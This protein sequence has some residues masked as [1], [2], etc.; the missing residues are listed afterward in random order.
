MNKIYNT[1]VRVMH[2]DNKSVS[3]IGLGCVTFGREIDQDTSFEMMNYAA[4]AGITLFDTS[5]SYGEGVSEEIVG[6]WLSRHPLNCHKISVSTKIQPPFDPSNILDSVDQSL[7]RLKMNKIDIVFLHRWDAAV[8]TLATL[9]SLDDLRKS[10]KVGMLGASNFSIDQLETI[11]GLQKKHGFHT[12]K[13]LQN[14]NNLVIR[15]INPDLEKFCL[16]NDIKIITYSPLGAGFLTGK[17]K[18]GVKEGTRFSVIKG[19]QDIYFNETSFKR[20]EQLQNLSF[21]TGYKPFYLALA[22]ALHRPNIASVLVG[23]RT[24]EQLEQAMSALN[25]NNADILNELELIK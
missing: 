20:L 7:R 10:G 3:A 15:D 5:P 4:S 23:G 17:Y 1:K 22:W 25:F 18:G 24:T 9:K 13:F 8:E 16:N 12:L 19:H 2:N 6:S 21:R 14:N 11:I